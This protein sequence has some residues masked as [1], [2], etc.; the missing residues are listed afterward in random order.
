MGL[1]PN[2]AGTIHTTP[3]QNLEPRIR[4]F[5]VVCIIGTGV[6]RN[7]YTYIPCT[8][9]VTAAVTCGVGR[10]IDTY[11]PFVLAF[12]ERTNDTYDPK[13]PTG[14]GARGLSEVSRDS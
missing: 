6:E 9:P 13:Y 7:R 1:A 4:V 14:G 8:E 3:P 10:E 11:I 12:V 5:W 2:P